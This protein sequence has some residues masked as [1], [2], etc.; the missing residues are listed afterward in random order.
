[1]VAVSVS[2]LSLF[3]GLVTAQRRGGTGVAVDSREH[4]PLDGKGK[5][6]DE[7]H[8]Q[9]HLCHKQEEDLV[10]EM[11]LVVFLAIFAS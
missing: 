2:S 9:T 4:L 6:D 5:R 1:M 7:E 8:E 10:V 3:K 11:V